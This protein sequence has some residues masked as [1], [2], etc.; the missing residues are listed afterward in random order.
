MK[1]KK[2]S[3]KSP[4]IVKAIER[5]F[6]VLANAEKIKALKESA[7]KETN[8]IKESTV[9]EDMLILKNLKRSSNAAS[10]DKWYST[11]KKTLPKK[12]NFFHSFENENAELA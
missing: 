6:S 12:P 3:L 9:N 10:P 7:E 2:D 1:E 4:A 8:D 5:R 11:K